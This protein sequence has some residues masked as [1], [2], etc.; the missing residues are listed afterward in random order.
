M[1]SAAVAQVC[2]RYGVPFLSLRVISDIHVSESEQRRSY[3]GFWNDISD[4]SFSVLARLL[5]AI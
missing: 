5:E 3:E 1:E 2:R 4:N